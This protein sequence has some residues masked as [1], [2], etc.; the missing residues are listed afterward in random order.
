MSELY[1]SDDRNNN[2]NYYYLLVLQAFS[3]T[4]LSNHALLRSLI[5]VDCYE[6]LKFRGALAY[7][8]SNAGR[9]GQKETFCDRSGRWDSFGKGEQEL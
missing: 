6:N 5:I 2:N 1:I 3:P 7:Y 9:K 8:S 4:H